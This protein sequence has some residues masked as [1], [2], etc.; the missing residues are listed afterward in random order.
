MGTIIHEKKNPFFI[1]ALLLMLFIKDEEILKGISKSQNIF[2][3]FKNKGIIKPVYFA[4]LLGGAQGVFVS[5][6]PLASSQ[7]L[8]QANISVFFYGPGLNRRG[9]SSAYLQAN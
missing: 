8:G 9:H 6:I 5:F 7:K 3:I 2:S 1:T 4:L